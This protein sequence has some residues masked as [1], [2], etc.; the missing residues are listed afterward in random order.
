MSGKFLSTRKLKHRLPKSES[1]S[2]YSSHGSLNSDL[3]GTIDAREKLVV[4]RKFKEVDNNLQQ[5]RD[6]EELRMLKMRNNLLLESSL[7]PYIDTRY[8]LGAEF[9]HRSEHSGISPTLM[10]GTVIPKRQFAKD[11]TTGYLQSSAEMY[12]GSG[13]H[14]KLGD[15]RGQYGSAMENHRGFKRLADEMSMGPS[16]IDYYELKAKCEFTAED[17]EN[18]FYEVDEYVEYKIK[19]E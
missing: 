18:D 4:N 6:L 19:C 15:I 7:P 17:A 9:E 12:S 5:L 2:A 13:V 16:D 3:S 11:L 10:S 1:G 8:G 14:A